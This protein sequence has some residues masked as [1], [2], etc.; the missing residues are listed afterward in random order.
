MEWISPMQKTLD[1]LDLNENQLTQLETFKKMNFS[2]LNRLNIIGNNFNCNKLQQLFNTNE[3]KTLAK[4]LVKSSSVIESDG[5]RVLICVEK[6]LMNVTEPNPK[7]NIQ[8]VTC[9]S[10][11]F[12]KIKTIKENSVETTPNIDSVFITS[13][14]L[15]KKN[16]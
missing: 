6:R 10:D 3:G 8:N 4:S 12:N 1:L 2:A 13:T 5:V 14:H 11:S 16:I 9:D 7:K 15:K